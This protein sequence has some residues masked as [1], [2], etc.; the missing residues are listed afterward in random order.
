MALDLETIGIGV[1]T[2]Q[3]SQ[4]RDELGRFATA[5][6]RAARAADGL[7][8]SAK[9]TTT[10]VG[11]M[12]MAAKAMGSAW[13]SWQVG[14][15]VRDMAMLASRFE[16][17]GVVMRIAGNNAG[18][19]MKQMESFSQALQTS[20]ISML[21][22]RNVLTQLATAQIDLANASKLGRA[23][24]DLAVVGNIN[25]SDALQRM[26]HGIKSG[27]VEILRTIGLN[28]TFEGGYKRLA[29]SLGTTS[30]KLTEQQKMLARTNEVLRESSRYTGIYEE[31]MTTAGKAI[32]SLTRYWEEFKVKAGAAFLP[33]LATSVFGLTDALKAMNAELDKAAGQ[34]TIA[35]VAGFLNDVLKVAFETAAVVAANLV[36]VLGRVGAEIGGI[37]AQGAAIADDIFSKPKV[38]G[39]GSAGFERAAEIRKQMIADAEAARKALDA[40]E[41]KIMG[42]SAAAAEKAASAARAA[43]SA[44]GGEQGRFGKEGAQI[45][46]GEAARATAE[47]ERKAAEAATAKAKA[48]KDAAKDYEA[49][50]KHSTEYAASLDREQKEIGLT[51]EQ[52]KMLKSAREAAKAPTAA[53]ALLVMSN[54]AALSWE[55][56]QFKDNEAAVKAANA[57]RDRFADEAFGADKKTNESNESQIKSANEMLKQL[58]FD[59]KLL[60]MNNEQRAVAIAMRKLETEGIVAGTLAYDAF[61]KKIKDAAIAGEAARADVDAAKKIADEVKREEDARVKRTEGIA[62]SIEDGIMNGFREGAKWSDI[63]LRELKAQFARTVLRPIINPIAAEMESGLSGIFKG[64]AGLFGGGISSLLPSVTGA[65]GVGPTGFAGG[66]YTGDAPRSGGLDGQ[67]GFLAMMHPQ[68]TVTDHTRGQSAPR[69]S[70]KSVVVHNSPVF[71]IDSR[72]DSGEVLSIMKQ[73]F[74]ENNKQLM[75][76]LQK[77]GVFA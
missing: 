72:T 21:Q 57:E 43:A 17:M 70:G 31:S 26:V 67:G 16:T 12:A 76:R 6:D 20:G 28:V 38:R 75:Y 50:V 11:Y 58:E 62:D 4:A 68:E 48:M 52:L 64:I 8:D 49:A 9:K 7:T 66:G 71:H 3:V 35:N 36:F 2:R 29:A 56:K 45:R 27:E 51:D 41:S 23:A 24:Q 44:W 54:A 77:L 60:G 59:T 13:A 63:F 5:G 10:A 34:G 30:E 42:A 74:D 69:S 25:S 15:L 40:F 33:A 18:Y 39:G 1:E 19:T 46:A 32:T 53:L 73:G 65:F 61:A 22:S 37:M 55:T 14:G 47:A